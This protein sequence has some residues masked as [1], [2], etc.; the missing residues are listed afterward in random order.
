MK[1]LFDNPQL[2]AFVISVIVTLAFVGILAYAMIY[3]IKDNPGLQI[4]T[5][6]LVSAFQAVVSYWIGSSSG[7]KNKDAVIAQQASSAAR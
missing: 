1:A 5:G 3:G 6:A 4:L 7:S 2:G